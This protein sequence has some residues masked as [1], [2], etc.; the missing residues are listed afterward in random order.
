M[1]K[2]GPSEEVT[3]EQ[4]REDEE[5]LSGFPGGKREPGSDRGQQGCPR[6]GVCLVSLRSSN[7]PAGAGDKPPSPSLWVPIPFPFSSLFHPCDRCLGRHFG[8]SH[9]SGTNEALLL[10]MGN[11]TLQEGDV[12]TGLKVLLQGTLMGPR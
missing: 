6:A 5:A 7:E 8:N 11:H 10:S 2:L 4:E 1:V 3:F 9:P 12:R